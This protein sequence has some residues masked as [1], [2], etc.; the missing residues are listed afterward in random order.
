MTLVLESLQSFILA[1]P[2]IVTF[3]ISLVAITLT[4][5]LVA[6][7]IKDKDLVLD[8]HAREDWNSLLKY[9]NSQE[10]CISIHNSST[11]TT[12]MKREAAMLTDSLNGICFPV[13]INNLHANQSVLFRLAN[14]IQLVGHISLKEWERSCSNH[15]S[16]LERNASVAITLI[17][18]A[19]LKTQNASSWVFLSGLPHPQ[20]PSSN[21]CQNVEVPSQVAGKISLNNFSNFQ[22][23]SEVNNSVCRTDELIRLLYI[24]SSMPEV[25]L[26]MDDKLQIYSHL[27]QIGCVFLGILF[28]LL[29][30]GVVQGRTL[31]LTRQH[32]LL[33]TKEIL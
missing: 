24:S 10:L 11:V 21:L 23:Y 17:V 9:L 5:F 29:I 30:S 12:G 33:P 4:I 14:S 2:P 18:P 25:Y 15:V 31:V 28:L 16:Q 19:G 32:T 6:F 27:L 22:S 1:R 13:Q 3:F 8:P 26:T 7:Y 20:L